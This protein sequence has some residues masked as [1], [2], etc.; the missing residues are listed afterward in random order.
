MILCIGNGHRKRP[1]DELAFVDAASK[2]MQP[3][4]R[5][6]E[7]LGKARKSQE[8]EGKARKR[9][10]SFLSKNRPEIPTRFGVP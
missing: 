3:R 9:T 6:S 10:F 1:A 8:K 4:F 5:P 7:K 2:G